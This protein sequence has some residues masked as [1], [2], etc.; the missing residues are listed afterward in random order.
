LIDYY[1]EETKEDII[2]RV[3]KNCMDAD[4][5]KKNEKREVVFMSKFNKSTRKEGNEI[6]KNIKKLLGI[7]R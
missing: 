3:N 5:M 1:T 6:Y 2:R 7:K 4:K